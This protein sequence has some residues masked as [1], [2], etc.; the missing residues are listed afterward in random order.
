M[1]G[2]CWTGTGSGLSASQRAKRPGGGGGNPQ[3]APRGR[4]SVPRLHPTP[5]AG[6]GADRVS[7]GSPCRSIG[8]S[9]V[10]GRRRQLAVQDDR[11]HYLQPRPRVIPGSGP[12]RTHVLLPLASLC[13][14]T[15][16]HPR[17]GTAAAEKHSSPKASRDIPAL[18]AL[19]GQ[20]RGFQAYRYHNSNPYDIEKNQ[21]ISRP[22][23]PPISTRTAKPI[24][25]PMSD[26]SPTTDL[27]GGIRRPLLLIQ[28][29]TRHP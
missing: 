13:V 12:A 18:A 25:F 24:A 19:N 26:Q 9:D 8:R 29:C 20:N 16:Q 11:K 2:K 27:T 6:H 3:F 22:I 17:S 15:A 10:P 4:V 21:G 5:P 1:P 7:R 14:D 23:T 28:P